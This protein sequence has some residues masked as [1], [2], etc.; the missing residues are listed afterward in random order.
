MINGDPKQIGYGLF[1]TGVSVGVHVGGAQIVGQGSGTFMPGFVRA[2]AL[3]IAVDAAA[4][5]A[6]EAGPIINLVTQ[7]RSEREREEPPKVPCS[8]GKEGGCL[9]LG[10]GSFGGAGASGRW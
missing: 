6:T 1:W 4:H 9:Q 7:P 10:G 2:V 8:D 5:A 3:E